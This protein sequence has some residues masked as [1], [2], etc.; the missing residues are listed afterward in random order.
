MSKIITDKSNIIAIANAVRNKT[1]NNKGMSLNGIIDEITFGRFNLPELKNE[2]TAE[3]LVLGKELI[4]DEGEVVTGTNPYAKVETDAVVDE[5]TDIINQIASVLEGKAS[6]DGVELP[7]LTNPGTAADLVIGKELIDGNGNVVVGTHECSDPVLQSKT[8]TPSTTQQN[9]T[10]DNG[11]DGLS[12]VTVNGDANLVPEN[13]ISGKSIFG[14]VGSAIA[15]GDSG[16]KMISVTH[17]D[18][19]AA[20]HAY[21][22]NSSYD[23]VTVDRGSTVSA[24]GGIIMYFGTYSFYLLSGDYVVYDTGFYGN[25][26]VRFNADGGEFALMNSG[27][28]N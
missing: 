13:I 12:K 21:Y 23:L 24:M 10:P 22:F 3:D 20:Y 5:Q 7:E 25:Q 4:N 26:I 19:S 2:G 1:G 28:S 8:I 16:P 11:Y 14:V 17:S 6:G 15:G 9:V 18:I 27:G